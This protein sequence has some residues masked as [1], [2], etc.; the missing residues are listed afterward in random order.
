LLKRQGNLRMSEC[1]GKCAN[2]TKRCE[3]ARL[4]GKKGTALMARNSPKAVLDQV[5]LPKG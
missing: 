3:A 4:I 1:T 5:P 2:R